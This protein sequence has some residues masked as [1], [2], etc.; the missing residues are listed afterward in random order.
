M[1]QGS[2]NNINFNIICNSM[3]LQQNKDNGQF[4]INLPK[5]VVNLLQWKAGV[6]INIQA[7]NRSGVIEIKRK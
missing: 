3:K 4:F 2:E 6:E 7:G 5:S 1:A